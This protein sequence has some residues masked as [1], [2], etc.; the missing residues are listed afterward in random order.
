M[1]EENMNRGRRAFT[2]IELL[3]VIGIITVLLAILIPVVSKVRLTAQ[4]ANTTAEMHRISAAIGNYFNDFQAYP[5]VLSN[6]D[7]A[8]PSTL[9]TKLA[10]VGTSADYTQSEDLVMALRGGWALNGGQLNF[11]PAEVGLGPIS[12]NTVV[13]SPR[14]NAYIE[15]NPGDFP[16]APPAPSDP[17]RIPV[18]KRLADMPNDLP[19]LSYAVDT[20]APEYLDTYSTQR[21]ILYLRANAS[22]PS[23]NV[24]YNSRA[25]GF[26]SNFQY[27]VGPM[28][29]YLR[30]PSKFPDGPCD[31]PIAGQ[32]NKYAFNGT[33]VDPTAKVVIDL[34]AGSGNN[35]ARSAGSYLLIDAGVD[36]I[37][38]T[39]DDIVVGAGGGQ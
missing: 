37:F 9:S 33:H 31:F 32:N 15:S 30:N 18:Y 7:F 29:G 21:P 24:V 11:V 17:K 34:F 8:M 36:R 2:L 14:K 39:D 6:A 4:T 12:F 10:G 26:K 5:G 13:V 25:G 22:A 1:R 38:G 27:D 28:E 23:T 20:I 35:T 19:E 3:V 16:P